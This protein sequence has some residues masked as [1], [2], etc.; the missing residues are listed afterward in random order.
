VPQL[1]E[2]LRFLEE[3]AKRAASEEAR[4]QHLDRDGSPRRILLALVDTTHAPFGDHPQHFDA[5]DGDADE[6]VIRRLP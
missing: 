6:W 4:P 5:T 3:P 2:D 1:T